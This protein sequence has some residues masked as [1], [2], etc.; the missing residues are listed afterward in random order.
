MLPEVAGR[1]QS[2]CMQRCTAACSTDTLTTSRPP[3]SLPAVESARSPSFLRRGLTW[4]SFTQRR[5]SQQLM[6]QPPELHPNQTQ[7]PLASAQITPRVQPSMLPTPRLGPG[8]AVP[9]LPLLADGSS[10]RLTPQQTLPGATAIASA[11][12]RAASEA[13]AAAEAQQQQ[14]VVANGAAEQQ[15]QQSAANGSTAAAA[16]AAADDSELLTWRSDA[17]Q[18]PEQQL[19]PE[20]LPCSPTGAAAAGSLSQRARGR[21]VEPGVAAACRRRQGGVVC[22]PA[23]CSPPAAPHTTPCPCTLPLGSAPPLGAIQEQSG[24]PRSDEQ[25]EGQQEAPTSASDQQG[26]AASAAA[27]QQAQQ[28][29]QATGGAVPFNL[30][31]LRSVSPPPPSALE[32]PTGSIASSATSTP[33][34]AGV[35][36]RGLPLPASVPRISLQAAPA[37]KLQPQRESND[38]HAYAD[39]VSE[40]SASVHGTARLGGADQ[41]QQQGQANGPASPDSDAASPV[42]VSVRRRATAPLPGAAG[43]GDLSELLDGVAT[44]GRGGGLGYLASAPATARSP[45][46]LSPAGSERPSAAPGGSGA[47]AAAGMHR[48]SQSAGPSDAAPGNCHADATPS[49]HGSS[50][51][52]GG[53]GGGGGLART[54]SAPAGGRQLASAAE[55]ERRQALYRQRGAATVVLGRDA[56]AADLASAEA[57]AIQSRINSRLSHKV[58]DRLVQVRQEAAA[59]VQAGD[60]SLWECWWATCPLCPRPRPVP[61]CTEPA[62]LAP[63]PAPPQDLLKLARYRIVGA[64]VAPSAAQ[65]HSRMPTT[66]LAARHLRR[67]ST[68]LVGERGGGGHESRLSSLEDEVPGGGGS[69]AAHGARPPARLGAGVPAV[70]VSRQA[71]QGP[72]EVLLFFGIIDFLQVGSRRAVP[73]C[74][75]AVGGGHRG[76]TAH[77]SPTITCP[78][79]FPCHS[80]THVPPTPPQEYNMRKKLEHGFKSVVQDGKAI[81]GEG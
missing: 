51:Q 44:S 31:R 60:A 80:P 58:S 7:Q 8:G 62:P 14:G 73:D 77:A 6:A 46:P 19:L 27:Q 43:S 38:W 37:P 18:L 11:I 74:A 12:K 72:E 70:A 56:S 78:T 34:A 75:C 42:A 28:Q 13:A 47:A 30:P 50:R 24:S 5:P 21:Q 36:P 45:S 16:A 69:I 52:Q 61:Q 59:A 1:C 39:T 57:A 20:G 25:Q 49:P 54:I 4:R 10:R 22:A 32:S 79:H 29:A 40:A 76:V 67:A 2:V 55:A 33:L 64:A 17:V 71:G 15:Q 3:T 81:S 9:P 68:G 65:R 23:A 26:A 53:S 66:V 35:S 41:Q 48:L 63:A